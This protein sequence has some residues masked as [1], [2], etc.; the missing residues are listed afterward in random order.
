MMTAAV[1]IDCLAHHCV[2]L[3]MNHPSY[4]L[5]A[6]RNRL[7]EAADSWAKGT[8]RM[9]TARWQGIHLLRPDGEVSV[10]GALGPAD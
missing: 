8:A 10:L 1:A 7:A 2:I 6:A 9:H 5:E 3:E 4:R